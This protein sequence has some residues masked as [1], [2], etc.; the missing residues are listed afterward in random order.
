[1]TWMDARVDNRVITPRMGKPVEIEALWY[2]ALKIFETLLTM[3]GETEQAGEIAGKA[4]LAKK[5]FDEKF[6]YPEGSYLADVIDPDGNPD[7]R[8]RPNQVFALSLPFHL[9][10][11]EKAR[12]V[13][14]IIRSKLYTPVGL[15]SL[16]PDDPEYKG[17]YGGNTL[18]RDSAYHQGTVW[19]WLLGPFIEAGMKTEGETFKRE[20]FEM[21]VQ[22]ANHLNEACIGTV[23]EIF[24]GDA[25]HHPRGCVAQAWSVAE[26]LRVAKKYFLFVDG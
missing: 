24:D 25:P 12:S 13:I 15:R 16:S 9:T 5:S 20:A 4:E 18:L 21:I 11:G 2:N 26:I 10:D 1:L 17:H 19:S 6:W 3:N 7:Y 23:S 14:N 8:I 22:M